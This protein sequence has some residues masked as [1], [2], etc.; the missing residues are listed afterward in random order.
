[1]KA[2]AP[3]GTIRVERASEIEKN[4]ATHCRTTLE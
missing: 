2:H 3:A 4:Q 1:V